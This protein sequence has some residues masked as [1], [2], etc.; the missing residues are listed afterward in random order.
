MNDSEQRA[1]A[2]PACVE[3]DRLASQ[4]M[5]ELSTASAIQLELPAYF[6]FLSLSSEFLWM[7]AVFLSL[8]LHCDLSLSDDGYVSRTTVF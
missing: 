7:S 6:A 8:V 3:N 2:W 5:H 4:Q 1:L